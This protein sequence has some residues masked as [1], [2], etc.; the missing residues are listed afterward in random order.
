LKNI[1]GK[2][3]ITEINVD[4]IERKKFTLHTPSFRIPIDIL[5]TNIK[6]LG[7]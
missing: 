6:I 3:V 7:Y 2:P 4:R 5:S 1:V